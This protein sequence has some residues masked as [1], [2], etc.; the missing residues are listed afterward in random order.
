MK[1][2]IMV[3]LLISST[4]AQQF[5]DVT[6]KGSPVSLSVKHYYADMGP[7]TAVRNN[8]AKGILAM[9]AIVTTTDDQGRVVPCESHMDFAF[10]DGILAP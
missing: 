1:S 4:F 2:I 6:A 3:I 5:Q 9:F 10:N 8:S 7:Y